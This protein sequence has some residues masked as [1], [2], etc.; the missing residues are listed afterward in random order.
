[1]LLGQSAGSGQPW[2][3]TS[4]AQKFCSESKM[5]CEKHEVDSFDGEASSF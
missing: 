5:I 3:K 1:M 4:S 2:S